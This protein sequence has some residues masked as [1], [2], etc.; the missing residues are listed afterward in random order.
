M[1]QNRS[2]SG[3][4]YGQRVSLV[5]E[6]LHVIQLAFPPFGQP[7]RIRPF[8]QFLT[9]DG[10]STGSSD[11]GIDGSDTPV[12]F[13]I[14][15]DNENDKYIKE[16]SIIVAYGLAGQPNEWADGVA[17]TN[18]SRLFYT[19]ERGEVEIDVIK[20]NQD[21]FRLNITPFV[22]SWE[23]RHVNATNDFGYFVNIDLTKFGSADGI[24]IDAGSQQRI[25]MTIRDNAG[26]DA[27][28]FNVVATGFERFKD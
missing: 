15:A 25:T 5:D 1:G 3:D 26:A 19:S 24:K 13:F 17:L 6:A 10:S 8:K 21:L 28:T 12:D 18:G 27:D 14:P 23:V 2:P 16:L 4:K 7:V 9:D 20:M 22:T 11:M